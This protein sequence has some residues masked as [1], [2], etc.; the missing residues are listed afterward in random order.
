LIA[1]QKE[2]QERGVQLVSVCVSL[3]PEDDLAAMKSRAEGKVFNFPY[4]SDPSQA[5]GRIYGA[6]TTPE[7]FVLDANR[8]VAYM[9]KIDDNWMSA[10]EVRKPYLRDALDAV[11]GGRTPAIPET[12]AVGCGIE[13]Q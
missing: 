5:M 6:R 2:Y 4:L 11:L 8:K 12:K 13:Y 9:G 7:V 1:I 10:D 3:G